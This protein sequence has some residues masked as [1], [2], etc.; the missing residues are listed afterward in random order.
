MLDAVV[1]FLRRHGPDRQL[2]PV[3]EKR[4]LL[5]GAR[6]R[7]LRAEDLVIAQ[8]DGDIA[9]VLGSWDQ[10]GFKQEIL[11]DPGTRLRRLRPVYDLLAR[12]IGARRLPRPGEPVRTAFGSLRCTADDD[13]DV[14][15]A[16][17]SGA[18]ARARQQGQAF[19][20][21]AFDA[22]EPLARA[23]GR[24]LAV[25]YESDVFLGAFPEDGLSLRLDDRPVHIEVGTL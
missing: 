12:A 19:L 17:L 11:A 10:S 2:F 6:Y 22:R 21:V 20:L 24:P 9:G 13:P 7:G 4:E 15:D 23:L 3:V 25:S 8:R 1:D 16:L 5:D 18:R 14:L